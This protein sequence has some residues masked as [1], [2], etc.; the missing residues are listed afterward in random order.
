MNQ[1]LQRLLQE[2]SECRDDVIFDLLDAELKNV[3][4]CEMGGLPDRRFI[5]HYIDGRSSL[6]IHGGIRLLHDTRL[7]FCAMLQAA[8]TDR[9][10]ATSVSEHFGGNEIGDGNVEMAVLVNVGEIGDQSHDLGSTFPMVRLQS[11]N[12]CKRGFGNPRQT[13]LKTVVHRRLLGRVEPER[14]TAVILPIT[15]QGNSERVELDQIESQIVEGGS[16]LIDDLSRNNGDIGRRLLE[17]VHCLI[18][19]RFRDDFVRLS[20]NVLTDDVLDEMKVFRCPTDFQRS[21]FESSEH[22]MRP[23]HSYSNS[24]LHSSLGKFGYASILSPINWQ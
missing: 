8:T 6:H 2:M 15:G 11:L 21:G 16:K 1:K 17:N 20:C 9:D 10:R 3:L 12:E 5:E 4:H 13:T 23:N 18:A 14:K 7:D 24:V 22:E 19:V